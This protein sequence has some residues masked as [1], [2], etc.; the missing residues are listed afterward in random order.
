[1]GGVHR[2]A[3]QT[4][5]VSADVGALT[6]HPRRL[7]TAG[8]KAILDLPRT[9][10]LLRSLSV[11]VVGLGTDDFPAFYSRSSGLPVPH[12]VPDAAGAAAVAAA[13]WRLGWPGGIVVANPVPAEHEIPAAELEPVIAAGVAEVSAAGITGAQVTPFLLRRVTEVIGPRGPAA[14]VARPSTTPLRGPPSPPRCVPLSSSRVM[15]RG[16]EDFDA[17]RCASAHWVHRLGVGAIVPSFDAGACSPAI[18]HLPGGNV[19]RTWRL[20]FALLALAL[21]AAACGVQRR[22]RHQRHHRGAGDDREHRYHSSTRD[23]R[24]RRDQRRRRDHRSARHDRRR[25]RAG[26]DFSACQVTDTGGVDDNS[27]NQTG[28]RRPHAGRGRARRRDDV[29]RVEGRDRL[30]ARTSSPSST[31]ECDLIVTVGFL[32]GDATAAAADGQPRAAVRHR[33]LRPYDADHLDNVRGPDLRHRRG[34]VPG[35][36]PGGRHDRDRHRRHLRRHQHPAG[37]DLHG[38]LRRRHRATTTRRTATT[39]QLLGWDRHQDGLFTGNFESTDDGRAFAKNLHRRGRRHHHAGGR[40]GRPRY[41]GARRRGGRQRQ[42][43]RGRRRRVRQR[44]PTYSAVY[45]TSV[46]KNMDDAVFDA[47]KAVVERRVR[48]RRRTSARWRTTASAWPRSTTS[49][50]TSRPS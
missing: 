40:P 29:A 7:V 9:L 35:R 21:V 37:H 15:L 38:R 16:D 3:L 4:G 5:D 45:L 50:T 39:S 10:E 12:R 33:R 48:G 27:F 47:I 6:R 8:A 43:H 22:R 19:K 31:Q 11:P 34:R 23:H 28:L 36:L 30:R 42:A 46:L 20:L 13:A 49:R 24:R 1:M 18:V 14:N 41:G 32:L 44:R 2:G 26:A 17:D 25:K